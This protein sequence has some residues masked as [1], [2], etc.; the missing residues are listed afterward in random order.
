MAIRRSPAFSASARTSAAEYDR[1]TES[2]PSWLATHLLRMHPVSRHDG[3]LSVRRSYST[4]E[5]RALAEK[6]GLQRIDIAVH[7]WLARLV[8]VLS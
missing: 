6:A 7:P 5:V 2:G 4:A 3:P 1:R 8:A